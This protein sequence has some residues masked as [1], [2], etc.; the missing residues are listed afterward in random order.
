MNF[1]RRDFIKGSA[2]T[3]AGLSFAGGSAFASGSFSY[4]KFNAL[5]AKKPNDKLNIGVIGVGGK[6]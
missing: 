1:K 5:A 3:A 2:L 6:G 4:P